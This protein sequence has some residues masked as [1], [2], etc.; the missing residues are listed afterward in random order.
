MSAQQET[1]RSTTASANA[2]K[3]NAVAAAVSAHQTTINLH[4]LSK[5]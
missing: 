3:A 5:N 2:T 1:Y 4:R